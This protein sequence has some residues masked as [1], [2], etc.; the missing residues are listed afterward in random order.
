MI[1]LPTDAEQVRV[2]EK[3]LIGG[4]SC[5]NTRLAFDTQILLPDKESEKAIFNL[6]INGAKKKRISTKILKMDENNQYGQAMTKP[7]PHG[8]IKKQKYVP[9]LVEL[10]MLLDTFGYLFIADI[11]F[12]NIKEKTLLLNEIYPPIFEK[13]KKKM[14]PFEKSTV[15]LMSILFRSKEKVTINSVRYTSKTHSTL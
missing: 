12:H 13:K 4:F 6:E 15:K 7:L 2:F 5:V 8:C 1:A 9:S 11:K 10:N 14:E 3:T